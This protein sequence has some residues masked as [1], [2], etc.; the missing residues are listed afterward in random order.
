MINGYVNLPTEL[1]EDIYERF[2]DGNL[3][4]P[5]IYRKV[6]DIYELRKPVVAHFNIGP[7]GGVTSVATIAFNDDNSY[8][9]TVNLGGEF[10]IMVITDDDYARIAQPG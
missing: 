3:H 4:I 7:L 6:R 10:L 1:T 9:I 2:I 8:M 5:G